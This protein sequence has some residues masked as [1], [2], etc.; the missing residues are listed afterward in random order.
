MFGMCISSFLSWILVVKRA[1]F[2]RC[3]PH[4]W[5][6]QKGKNAF[7]QKEP[8]FAGSLHLPWST[9]KTVLIDKHDD[10]AQRQ[11]SGS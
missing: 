11:R 7:H 8:A 3:L 5:L 2:G 6:P 1:F 4:G 9:F 10:K